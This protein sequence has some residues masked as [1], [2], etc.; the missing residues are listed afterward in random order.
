MSKFYFEAEISSFKTYYMKKTIL[1]FALIAIFS[2]CK[3]NKNTAP[4]DV[5]LVQDTFRMY[6]NSI[7]TDKEKE[8]IINTGTVNRKA[9]TSSSRTNSSVN[10]N[11]SASTAASSSSANPA[12]VPAKKKG[13]SHAAKGAAVGAGT[14]AITGAIINSKHRGTGAV[15]GTVIGAATGYVIGRAKDKKDG[16]N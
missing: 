14:G 11:T 2:A 1:F 10:K 16:R 4:R 15:V 7:L 5:V 13:W 3:N 6:N 8:Q 12:T 9:S